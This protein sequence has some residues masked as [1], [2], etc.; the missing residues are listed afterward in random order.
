MIHD[1]RYA[2]RALIRRPGFAA[3]VIITLALGIGANVALFS[4]VNGVLLRPLPFPK[5]DQLVTF[6][7]SKQNF[8][9]GAVPYP[10][11]LDLQRENQTFSAMAIS[12][13]AS[14]SLV[15]IGDPARVE[16]R[17]VS[18]DYFSLLGVNP[19]LGRTFGAE[20]ER[21]DGPRVVMISEKFWSR[22]FGSSKDV[23]GK[24]L[25]LDDGEYGVVGVVPNSFN[26]SPNSDVYLSLSQW[27]NSAL[28]NRGAA[29]GLHGIGRL[30]P[31]VTIEQAQNDLDR[32]MQ[33]LA[34]Q[35]P[36]TN[37]GNGAR[38]ISLKEQMTGDV[39]SVLLILFAAVGF[40]L[41]IAVVNVSNLL[42]ARATG[43]SQEF[44]IRVA[45]GAGQSRLLRQVI[46]ESTLIAIVGGSLGLLLAAWTTR[47]A[48]RALPDSLPRTNEVGLDMTVFLFA[49]AISIVAGLLA[50]LVPAIKSA[51]G[52]VG[53]TLKEGGR[54]IRGGRARAQQVFV[55]V[56]MALAL[57]LLVGAGLMIRSLHALWSVDPGFRAEGAMTFGVDLPASMSNAD[58]NLTRSVLQDLSQRVNSIPGVNSAS[59]YS[60]STPI[61]NSDDRFFWVAGQKPANQ[62]DMHMAIFYVVE[63]GYLAAMGLRLKRGRF[64]TS[65]D[66][67]HAPAVVVIDEALA[68]QYFNNEDPIG[69]HINLDDDVGP[70]EIVGVVGHIKQW[71]LE[72]DLTQTLQ[73]QLYLPLAGLSDT[74][75]SGTTN[76]DVI[77]RG[78]DNNVTSLLPP[79]RNIV[80]QQNS[81]N[82][83]S[84]TMTMDEVIANSLAQRRFSMLLLAVF[85]CVALCLA[86]IG[87]YGVV[88]Y[89]VGQRTHE[90]GIRIAL[91]ATKFNVIRLVVM[92]GMKMALTGIA[93]GGVAA[94]VLTRLMS[95]L[96]YGVTPT[97]PL[98]FLSIALL[99]SGV[100]F[101]ACYVP[102]LRAT[103][104]DPLVAL[105]YE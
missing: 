80:N 97:D 61:L 86:T 102:A 32:I 27:S 53:E 26:L 63:P 54:G 39:R 14:F 55:A 9:T 45:L 94:F 59:L 91:G 47:L 46:F 92:D 12:R 22:K 96:L 25:R 8:S 49:V 52:T 35:Y 18:T 89:L 5:P 6:H 3:V 85:A 23:L 90:L 98:T 2:I 40:V 16:G 104:V 73:A 44:A 43:R 33:R 76:V 93:V 72:A 11:F 28:K 13:G 41:L 70:R 31:G 1:F 64:F 77:V 37:K 17:F 100:A 34:E 101:V 103:K 30:K 68:H 7:Q 20:D 56:E 50:G 83:V 75:L 60:G 81:L 84:N 24:T 48:L 95:G 74:D 58:G 67:E 51:I 88:S 29:L 82:I 4:I 38:V 71:G 57:I 69:K 66:D 105:R 78:N 99:L 19:T 79:L 65:H 62:S 42:L 87:I 15:G 36:A 21:G 10:N